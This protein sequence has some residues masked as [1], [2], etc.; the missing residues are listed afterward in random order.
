ML[1]KVD[2]IIMIRR[3]GGF[4]RKSK[5]IIKTENGETVAYFGRVR[6]SE[7]WVRNVLKS[8]FAK[9]VITVNEQNIKKETTEL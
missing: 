2:K 8:N 6:K 5:A 1:K 9:I 4:K 7:K 3:Y